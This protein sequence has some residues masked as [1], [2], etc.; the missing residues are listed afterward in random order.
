M[1]DDTLFNDNVLYC[2]VLNCMIH[3]VC[4]R[5]SDPFYIVT[6]YIELG[7]TSWIGGKF[8]MFLFFFRI[9]V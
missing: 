8:F 1:N 2:I 3:T 7:T 9:E 5:N 6:Y 4:P